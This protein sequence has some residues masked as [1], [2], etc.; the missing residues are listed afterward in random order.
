MRCVAG[1]KFHFFP[2]KV[3]H[4][5]LFMPCLSSE[6]SSAA[7]LDLLFLVLNCVCLVGSRCFG[8]TETLVVKNREAGVAM[9]MKK[10]L[11]LVSVIAC[12]VA[13][14]VRWSNG[15]P[16][17][18]S[19]EEPYIA[20]VEYESTGQY[21]LRAKIEDE[22]GVIVGIGY[23]DI[24]ETAKL[25]RASVHVKFLGSI[26][27]GEFY[28]VTVIVYSGSRVLASVAAELLAFE[29][30]ARFAAGPVQV[31]CVSPHHVNVVY[32][33]TEKR[34][35][36]VILRDA[37]DTINFGY[38]KTTV[39]PGTAQKTT[40]RVRYARGEDLSTRQK[41]ILRIDLRPANAPKRE[42]VDRAE[43]VVICSDSK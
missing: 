36:V 28:T 14:S 22:R 17:S 18:L 9:Y 33:A 23:L 43:V 26:V 8:A 34:D 41:V 3:V 39:L 31:P 19:V 2:L 4:L 40:I 32:T 35:I 15:S 5:F 11:F 7:H 12:C 42:R 6:A 16:T 10:F 38:G 37:T 20:H 13:D 1:S 25:T 30:S 27:S 24:V 21:L 29:D